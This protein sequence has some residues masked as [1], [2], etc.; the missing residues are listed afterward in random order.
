MKNL[1]PHRN[2]RRAVCF[3]LA[4]AAITSH[5]ENA[6]SPKE[7]HAI[8]IANPKGGSSADAVRNQVI[9]RLKKS[10]DLRIVSDEAS[11]DATL[12]VSAVI[13]PSGTEIPNPRSRNASPSSFQG[14]ASAELVDQAQQPLWSY[15]ATP[16]RFHLVS[17]ATDLGDQLSAQLVL[18]ADKG[19]R[20]LPLNAPTRGQSTSILKVAG[21][22]F[23]APL[24]QKW[25]ESFR[26]EERG[27][28][29]RYDAIGSAQGLE[30][31]RAKRIDVAASDIALLPEDAG[32]NTQQF[33]SVV[34]GVVP[35]YNLPGLEQSTLNFTPD[36]LALIYSGEVTQWNDPRIRAL[37]HNL[38]L[39]NAP[40]HVWHRSDGSGTTYLWTSFLSTA[41]TQ[42]KS[43]AG[44]TITWPTGSGV[45]G[46]EGM[47]E[48]VAEVADSIGY[49]ELT[50]AI[51][52]R[53]NYGAVRNRS[54]HFIKADLASLSAAASQT[55]ANKLPASILDSSRPGA[56]PIAAF[57]WL[58]VPET[59]DPAKHKLEADLLQ[60][61]FSAGQ[62]QC[63]S[64][65]YA[66]LPPEV[67][68]QELKAISKL[69]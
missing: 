10:S 17:T 42:W 8:Y 44:A 36:L 33:P 67:V 43:S 23:P 59:A 52:H 25:F 18:D 9:R 57:T 19:I 34:G 28:A 64:L 24:Y 41:S 6:G 1:N 16:S 63:S 47:V 49:V 14:Y 51:Q 21:A 56:Y 11:A 39:P 45:A 3:I 32:S 46:S 62:R 58:L 65:A 2:Y 26:E 5:A 12:R 68:Q 13:W 22:T 38:H 48:K 15:L 31:L 4:L 53:A 30:Q 69:K 60:W 61:I 55:E 40:I 35:I 66:P 50:Y 7:I 27:P 29:I 20:L 54:G 37:N